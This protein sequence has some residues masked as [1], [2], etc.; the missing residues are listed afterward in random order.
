VNNNLISTRDVEKD[1]IIANVTQEAVK[2]SSYSSSSFSPDLRKKFLFSVPNFV[3]KKTNFSA[4]VF[5]TIFKPA[6]VD[7]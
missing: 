7:Y 6:T 4:S 1:T 2:Q 5:S 3:E